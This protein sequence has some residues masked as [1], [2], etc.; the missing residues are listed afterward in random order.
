MTTTL[1][2]KKIAMHAAETAYH[3]MI[4]YDAYGKAAGA[5]EVDGMNYE[6]LVAYGSICVT[7]Q[8]GNEVTSKCIDAN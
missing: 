4:A 2:Q 6:W 5:R 3:G 7:Y 8:V 1:Q